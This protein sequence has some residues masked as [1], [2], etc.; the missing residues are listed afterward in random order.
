MFVNLFV[1]KHGSWTIDKIAVYDIATSYMIYLMV[2]SV[3]YRQVEYKRL[4][5]DNF[6]H[7]V[8]NW[9]FSI[10]LGI[11]LPEFNKATC[12]DMFSILLLSLNH[13]F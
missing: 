2:Y 13:K 12:K 3:N 8:Q 10:F 6:M 4:R 11:I 1:I 5:F 7:T 9:Q